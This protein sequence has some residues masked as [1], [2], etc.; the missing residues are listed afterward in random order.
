MLDSKKKTDYN[1]LGVIYLYDFL[2]IIR[3]NDKTNMKPLTSNLLDLTVPAK[4]N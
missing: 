4:S 3:T 1:N 2:P